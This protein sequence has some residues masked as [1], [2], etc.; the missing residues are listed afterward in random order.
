[1]FKVMAVITA[2]LP[3]MIAGL[4]L[5]FAIEQIFKPRFR[6]PWRRPL[7]AIAAHL[8]LWLGYFVLGFILCRRPG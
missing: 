2:L 3:S 6:A 8:G 5:S 4:A 1:M 7:P